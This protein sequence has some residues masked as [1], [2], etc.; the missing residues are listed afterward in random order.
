MSDFISLALGSS[1]A[2]VLGILGA[3][4]LVGWLHLLRAVRRIEA[5]LAK[6][7]KEIQ[8]LARAAERNLLLSLR[9]TAELAPPIAPS[10]V[11]VAEPEV[12]PLSS[13]V[14]GQDRPN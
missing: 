3:L 8:E 5:R 6:M 9:S 14:N 1:E 13:V 7:S 2:V 12:K 4:L 11:S 10:T